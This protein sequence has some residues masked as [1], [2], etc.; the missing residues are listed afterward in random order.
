MNEEV[1]CLAFLA[2][3][4]ELRFRCF[5]QGCRGDW[6]IWGFVVRSVSE[7][8][9]VAVTFATRTFAFQAYWLSFIALD[10]PDSVSDS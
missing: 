1:E 2:G 4:Q 9:K 3:F 6:D 7:N 10:T 5:D 8:V